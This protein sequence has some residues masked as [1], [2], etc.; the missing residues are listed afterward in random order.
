MSVQLS[1]AMILMPDRG[2]RVL[3]KGVLPTAPVNPSTAREVNVRFKGLNLRALNMTSFHLGP[4]IWLVKM[5]TP[6]TL[7]RVR[8]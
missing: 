5:S 3:T 8:M 7:A 6:R 2:R 4:C 1:A